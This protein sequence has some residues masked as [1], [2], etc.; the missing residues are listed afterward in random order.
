MEQLK[1][2]ASELEYRMSVLKLD[3]I[4]PFAVLAICLTACG[5]SKSSAPPP[6][7]PIPVNVTLGS[8]GGTITLQSQAGRYTLNGQAITS[9]HTVKGSNGQD[10]AL[11]L[12]NGRWTAEYE[13][14]PPET[15]TLGQSGHQVTVTRHEDG[16]YQAGNERFQKKGQV[17]A[18]NGSRYTLSL[19]DGEWVPEYIAPAAQTVALGGSGDQVTLA[20]NED[21]TFRAGQ[22]D[23]ADGE[24]VTSSNGGQYRLTLADGGWSATYEPPAPAVVILGK[25]GSQVVVT[26]HE[27][28][29][30]EAL[31]QRFESGAAVTAVNGSRYTLSLINGEW[32]PEYI[33]PAAQTVALGGSG[34]QV[35]LARNEDGTY[36]AGQVDIASGGEVTSSNGGKYR[37]TLTGGTWTA[38]YQPPPPAVITLGKSGLQLT[39]T[40]NQDGSFQAGDTRFENGGQWTAANGS[41]YTLTFANGSWR[42]EYVAPEPFSLTLGRSGFRVVFQRN[43]DGTYRANGLQFASGETWTVRSQKYRLTLAGGEWTY[44]WVPPPGQTVALGR[45]GESL[46]VTIQE[47][48]SYS[49]D[50]TPLVVGDSRTTENGNVYRLTRSGGTW[51]AQF[52]PREIPVVLGNSGVRVILVQEENGTYWLS[53]SAFQSGGTHTAANGDVYRLTLAN[54]QWSAEYVPEVI[55]VT[56]T[57]SQFSIPIVRV[58]DGTYWFAGRQIRSGDIVTAD[59][60]EYELTLRGRRW[61]A[62]FR[63][64]KEIVDLPSG[65]SITLSKRADGS[66][67]WNGRTIRSGRTYTVDGVRYRLTRGSSGWRAVRSISLPIVDL[68]SGSGTGDT[69]TIRSFEDSLSVGDDDDVGFGL[70]SGAGATRHRKGDGSILAVGPDENVVDYSM[71]DLLVSENLV[72]IE[73]RAGDA[74][75]VAIEEAIEKLQR[76]RP[77]Y[78]INPDDYLKGKST[79][80]PSRVLKEASHA[81]HRIP[82]ARNFPSTSPTS[83]RQFDSLIE[84]LQLVADSLSSASTSQ[85]YGIASSDF[86]TVTSKLV[87]GH[88]DDTRFVGYANRKTIDNEWAVGSFAYSTLEQLSSTESLPARGQYTYTGNTVAVLSS[89]PNKEHPKTYNGTIELVATFSS[90]LVEGKVS[91]L[92][93]ARGGALKVRGTLVGTV[94]LPDAKLERQEGKFSVDKTEISPQSDRLYGQFIREDATDAFGTWSVG[95]GDNKE[96]LYGAFGVDSPARK[97]LPGTLSNAKPAPNPTS[98]SEVQVQGQPATEISYVSHD[99]DQTKLTLAQLQLSGKSTSYEQIFMDWGTGSGTST[100]INIRRGSDVSVKIGDFYLR[101]TKFTRFGAW[102]IP[103]ESKNSDELAFAAFAYSPLAPSL[104]DDL[105]HLSFTAQYSG[106]T[107]VIV[108]HSGDTVSFHIGNVTAEVEWDPEGNDTMS[109]S[110]SEFRGVGSDTGL[111]R[112]NKIKFTTTTNLAEEVTISTAMGI[113][114][115]QLK[116]R[117]VGDS[118]DGPLGLFGEWKGTVS[119]LQVHGAF[120]TDIA[121]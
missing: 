88:T 114:E 60:N 20:R 45:S 52:E 33:A 38:T 35:T 67:T 22:A 105:K 28:G 100:P 95:F 63:A 89:L 21:G 109:V 120:G 87:F 25:S 5:G 92:K 53:G 99:R 2:A 41:R 30:Y 66:Y 74:A 102:H 16:S 4:V 110:M 106:K 73:S 96:K 56:V 83:L 37:L 76:Y 91:A 14:P 10:Y 75:K 43:E 17:T 70:R 80:S 113:S 77:L 1:Y 84:D 69:D 111:L 90:S 81:F 54:G 9:G 31:G 97:A 59:G 12:A 98:V 50:E 93:N 48:G 79:L 61:T 78:E 58:Q 82:G 29:S 23:I 86:E 47:D 7:Q 65:D 49:A 118:F 26:R 55:T 6:P 15:V 34:D 112:N 3:R 24:V 32:V 121:P 19:V 68:G 103:K 116:A 57:D 44:E 104:N 101:G 42:A 8:F 115:A 108:K 119:T 94:E 107:Q 51:S 71:D 72:R 46:V 64:G 13:P 18:E 40:R 85:D 117:F 62:R 27:D 11:T 36:G 39:A